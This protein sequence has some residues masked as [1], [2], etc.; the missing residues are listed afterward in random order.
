M[1]YFLKYSYYIGIA[2]VLAALMSL[3]THRLCFELIAVFTL[4]AYLLRLLDDYADYDTDVREKPLKKPVIRLL[5][6]VLSAVFLAVNLVFFGAKG[7]VCLLLLV[8]ALLQNRFEVMK[9]FFLTV[10]SALYLALYEKPLSLW[11]VVYLCAT[12]LLA[13]GFYLFKRH[14]TVK[15]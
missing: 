15:R 2:L 10:T 8:Y 9:L 1:R 14:R 5:T 6:A 11:S 7:L 13:V 12:L 4:L 3:L